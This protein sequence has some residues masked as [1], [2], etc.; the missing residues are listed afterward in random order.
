MKEVCLRKRKHT[1]FFRICTS[2]KAKPTCSG[3]AVLEKI[4]ITTASC[5]L[6]QQVHS[7]P[8]LRD[9]STGYFSMQRQFS[10]ALAVFVLVV[11]ALFTPT[12]WA[13]DPSH[14]PHANDHAHHH[15][16]DGHPNEHDHHHGEDGHKSEHEHHHGEDGHVS[17]HQHH[18]GDDGH[19]TEHEHHHI[20]GVDDEDHHHHAAEA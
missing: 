7:R 8:G 18:H 2:M 1:T 14:E 9:T 3:P 19:K 17:E 11:A 20:D 6:E 10:A 15:G 5:S 4:T 12:S 16:E 13:S